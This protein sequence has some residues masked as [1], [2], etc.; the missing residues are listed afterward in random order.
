MEKK[1]KRNLIFKGHILNTYVDDVILDDGKPGT[2]EVIE[3]NGGATIAIKKN[4]KYLMVRQYRYAQEMEMLEFVAGKIDL[5]EEPLETVLRE[6]IEETG[7]SVKNV[8]SLGWAAPSPAFL[9]EK[10]YMLVGEVDE[11]KGQHL[12]EGEVLNVEE[13]TLDELKA[14]VDK[15]EIVDAKTLLIIYKL[16]LEAK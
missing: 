4:D 10:L 9:T 13:Y 6:A 14:M 8:R 15:N 1:L 16:L 11:Y 5:G 2:R 7:Y 3:N 12:D